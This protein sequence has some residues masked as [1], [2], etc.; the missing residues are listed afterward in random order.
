MKLKIRRKIVHSKILLIGFSLAGGN[1]T[2]VE[3]NFITLN[4]KTTAT[5]NSVAIANNSDMIQ[6]ILF[7]F[8]YM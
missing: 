6:L 4:D 2:G 5:G 3:N 1:F 7:L 8:Y